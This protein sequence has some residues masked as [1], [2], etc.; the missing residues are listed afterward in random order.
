MLYQGE[1]SRVDPQRR[2]V[3]SRKDSRW[4]SAWLNSR[5]SGFD[6]GRG[7]D[8]FREDSRRYDVSSYTSRAAISVVS[9]ISS[10]IPGQV[11]VFVYSRGANP[12]SH[13]RHCG[14]ERFGGRKTPV[15]RLNLCGWIIEGWG[16]TSIIF[17]IWRK[18]E[19]SS[20]GN[21]GGREAMG[22]VTPQNRLRDFEK[23]LRDFPSPWCLLPGLLHRQLHE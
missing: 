15:E 9:L 20:C 8:C 19:L 11:V 6:P 22:L 2:A 5:D 17:E 16:S 4:C 21:H 12:Y 23:H 14:N 7:A 10:S 1:W 3:R 18:G 13:Q